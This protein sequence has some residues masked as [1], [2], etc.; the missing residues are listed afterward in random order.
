MKLKGKIIAFAGAVAL[1]AAL[2]IA[3][4][5][6][7][8]QLEAAESSGKTLRYVKND[9]FGYG[10]KLEYRVGYKFVT[11][12]TGYFQ[13]Q[14]N[15]VLVNG[16]ESYDVRF[17]VRSLKSLEWIYKVVDDYRTVLD[18]AGIFP[19]EFN[20]RIREG[21]YKKDYTAKFDQY[22][23]KAYVGKKSYNVPEYVHDIVSAFFYVRT[24]DLGSMKNGSTFYLKNFFD[25]ETNNLGV[26]VLKREKVSVAAGT[27]N[28]I[29]IE[30]LVVKGGLFKNE[31]NIFIWLTDDDRKIPV[32]VATKIL[33]G[34]V[35][36]ELTGYSGTRGPVAAK[37]G[38]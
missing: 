35:S 6:L 38:K 26:K 9:A 29:V 11:A 31:G 12:G 1:A 34:Y 14:P 33:I 37:V 16:R 24:M 8:G 17:Q 4:P 5:R 32:K 19:W 21:N 28:C 15:P 3:F 36:A 27:F 20:Q 30:P 7:D 25:D 18:V 10:E 22:N 13:I 23:N 2:S